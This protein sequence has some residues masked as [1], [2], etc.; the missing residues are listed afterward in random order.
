MAAGWVA[1]VAVG[2]GLVAL[3]LEALVTAMALGLV[4]WALVAWGLLAWLVWEAW[5]VALALAS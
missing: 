2:R 5:E 3:G 1:L 4:V